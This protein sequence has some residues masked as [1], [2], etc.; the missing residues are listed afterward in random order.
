MSTIDLNKILQYQNP[1]VIKRFKRN[2]PQYAEQAD[3][4]FC[5]MLKYLWLSKKHDID[6]KQNPSDP[7]LQFKCSMHKEMRIIDEMWHTFI[8]ITKD[9]A[10]FCNQ[11]FGEFMH[12]IPEI[13]D[14]T[15]EI[16]EIDAHQFEKEFSLFLSYAYDHLGEET[17]SRWF[18]VH[19]D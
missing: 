18:A 5:D 13:G 1:L 16:N 6:Y 4:L 17:I 14:E 15:D 2:F 9:Y 19:L 12:H 11:Y 8:L 10:E 7:L 3:S